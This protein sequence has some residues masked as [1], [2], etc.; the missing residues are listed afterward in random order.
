LANVGERAELVVALDEQR[1]VRVVK[2]K[3]CCARLGTQ[4]VFSRPPGNSSIGR[5]IKI[6][7]R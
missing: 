1:V 5:S 3:A 4:L 2:W 6:A 7:S